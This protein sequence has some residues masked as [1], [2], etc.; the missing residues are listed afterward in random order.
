MI[1]SCEVSKIRRS[2]SVCCRSTC[3]VLFASVMSRATFEM[4]M[5][6]PEGDLI[7]EMLSETSI[8]LPSFRSRIVSL[9]SMLSPQPIRRNA[10]W[11]SG[12]RS[13]G[14]SSVM[15]S[16]TASAAVYPNSRSAAEFQP[17]IVPS[18]DIV[19]MASLDDSTAALN[20]RSR[21]A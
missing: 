10:S 16:P 18:S 20:R 17:V 15:F 8:G 13:S 2:S 1:R 19:M 7:G 21:S 5:V 9:C 4:P 3:L 11:I 14:T 6:A 12:S